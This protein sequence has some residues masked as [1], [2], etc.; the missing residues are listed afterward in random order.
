MICPVCQS[1]NPADAKFCNQCGTPF[2]RSCPNCGATNPTTAR[3]CSNCGTR[4]DAVAAAISAL[5]PPSPT[6]AD[7]PPAGA[8][9]GRAEAAERPA[10]GGTAGPASPTDVPANGAAATPRAGRAAGSSGGQRAR[11]GSRNGTTRARTA[12]SQA[13]QL[14]RPRPSGAV[15]VLEHPTHAPLPPP[16]VHQHSVHEENEEQR[17]VVTVLFADLTSSTAI[18]DA[19]D[20]EDLR[21]MLGGFFAT[22]A[23]QIHRHGGTVEKYIGDAVMAVFGLPTAH[24][25]DPLRA[26]RAALDMQASLR[27]LNE[28]RRDGDDVLPELQMRIGINTGEVVAASGAVEGRDFLITGDPVN[29]AA[30]LQQVAA[31]GAIVIGARTFRGTAG[32]VEYRALPPVSVKGKSHPLRVWEAVSLVEPGI[33]PA[34]RPRGLQ[35]LQA[36]LVG[37]EVELTLLRS[38]YAR[39]SGERRPHLVTLMGVPG[40][41]KT[42][43][44]REFLALVA[45]GQEDADAMPSPNSPSQGTAETQPRD[46]IHRISASVSSVPSAAKPRLGGDDP[47]VLE[48]RC[49][50]YGEAITYWP[51]AEMLRA[52]CDF[53]ALTRPAEAR[54]RL[55]SCVRNTLVAAGRG[56]DPEVVATALGHTIGIETHE[57]RQALLP[58]DNQQLQEALH[59]AWRAFFEALAERQPLI[60]LVDD[61]HW[62]D[63]A[64]LDLLEYVAGRSTNVPLLLLCAARPEL[65][66]RRQA[67]GGG[68]RNYA[69]I[70]LEPLSEQDADLLAR[71]LLPGDGVPE[72]LRRSIQRKA[73]GNP[74]FFEEIVRMLVDRGIL[75]RSED[76]E[77]APLRLAPDREVGLDLADI[78]IPDTVQGV[79]AARLDLLDETERDILQHAAVIGRYF[80]PGALSALHPHLG[81]ALG[82]ALASLQAKDLIHEVERPEVAA[83]PPG[84]SL[85]T[86]NHAL[87]R[88]VAY[89]TI[90][91]H[92]RAHEHQHVAEWLEE[93]AQGREAEFADMIAQHYRQYY[94]QANLNR[95][96]NSPRRQAV[97]D[98]VVGYLMLA[99][100][101]SL[102]RHAAGKADRYY[103]DALVMLEEDAHSEDVPRRVALQVKRGEAR[104]TQARGDDAWDDYREALRLWSSYSAFLVEGTGEGGELKSSV[105]A[106]VG[107]DGE[108]VVVADLP[109]TERLAPAV[110]V[111]WREWGL[112]LYCALVVLP[113]RN[114]AFF[115]KAPDHEELLPYLQEGLRLAEELGQRETLEGAALLTAKAFFWWSWG[116]RRGERELL[117]ALKSAREAVRITEALDAPHEAS[118]ALDA[119]GNLQAITADLR[120][121]QESQTRRLHWARRIDDLTELVDIHGEVCSAHTLT[122]DLAEAVAHGRRALELADAT[123]TDVLRARALRTLVVAYTEW[124]HWLEAAEAGRKLEAVL[125]RSGAPISSQYRW[126][127]LAAAIAYARMGDRDEADRLAR[128]V[129]LTADRDEV[130]FV[131]LYRARFALARGATR[132]ARQVLLAAVDLP[133]GR[134][135]LPM[136]LAELAE[137]G[138]RGGDHE[139][140][141]RY[142]SQALELGWRS[143]A[144][145]AHAQAIRARGIVALADGCWEDAQCEFESALQRFQELGTPW[146]EARTRYAL[147]GLFARRGEPG[148][149]E[150]GHEELTAALAIFERLHAVRD[151]ARVRAALAGGGVRL[152]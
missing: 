93:L 34:Q 132:E 56:E 99:G 78:E 128:L 129:T 116:E 85:Y 42:R 58:A 23:R 33:A 127:G 53:T 80:W 152:P 87:T 22:M 73:E 63:E 43:L 48:G 74:F 15:G 98:K 13:S 54:A 60:L 146:E 75:I 104:W 106:P 131:A 148:D 67:W 66:E 9:G 94:V 126:A 39:V 115:Q 26:V 24:E 140:Y 76:D 50:Q 65:L 134:Q 4:L 51:L 109:A 91:R 130:Q 88:E 113:T 69:I 6:A 11:G 32:A 123:D 122:A 137:L 120:G 143:G 30:R 49:P 133:S 102:A 71:A 144:R 7:G 52:Y 40:V 10:D 28:R 64:L 17:R 119:L 31:P 86:F 41:G 107:A 84:E 25:D 16:S 90:P 135:M 141:N 27:R 81:G 20:A 136:L 19:M 142:I 57:H 62:A 138:A 92:R 108:A 46:E 29:V 55:L 139:L 36:P 82:P 68:K 44:A 112:R 77:A 45:P 3:F 2:A 121:Y 101:Q 14:E 47:L 100:D 8:S 70:N 96:R 117:D 5:A 125:R 79:L 118:E 18:A 1:E 110:P 89:S 59:R 95:S 105:S 114:S 38:L 151:I 21:E 37:R 147:S 61:I 111:D 150:R 145:K 124:D 35:G 97:R 12:A 83:V 149:A 72:S 103:T